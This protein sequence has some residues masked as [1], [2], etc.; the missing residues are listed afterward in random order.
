MNKYDKY[1]RPIHCT[2]LKREVLYI[3]ENNQ[4]IK[5]TDNKNMKQYIEKIAMKNC[6]KIALWQDTYQESKILDSPTYNLWLEIIG[7]SMNTGERGERNTEKVIKNIAKNVFIGGR[8]L[9]I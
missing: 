5:E 8:G 7:Q 6:Q 2:D 3:R 9:S 4:W 1:S